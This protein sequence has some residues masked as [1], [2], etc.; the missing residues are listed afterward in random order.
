MDKS[1]YRDKVSFIEG[2]AAGKSTWNDNLNHMVAKINGTVKA[3]LEKINIVCIDKTTNV[4][5]TTAIKTG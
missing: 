4:R 1:P 5:D 3:E 2:V